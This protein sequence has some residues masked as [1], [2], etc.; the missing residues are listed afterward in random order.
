VFRLSEASISCD[1]LLDEE[2]WI[3]SVVNQEFFG[4]TGSG[5]IVPDLPPDPRPDPTFLT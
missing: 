4:Q 1:R 5:I 3:S 2:T